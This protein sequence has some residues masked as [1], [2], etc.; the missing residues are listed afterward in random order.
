V[1]LNFR[2]NDIN[3]EKQ[4]ALV[5]HVNHRNQFQPWFRTVVKLA[6]PLLVQARRFT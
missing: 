3:R 1:E 6:C 2:L 4:L 5:L